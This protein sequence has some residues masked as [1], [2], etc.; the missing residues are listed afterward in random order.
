MITLICGLPNA[1][2]TTY[3]EQY[4][5]V[6]H[7]DSFTCRGGQFNNCNRLASELKGD[8]CV[9]GVYNSVR[10]RKEFLEACKSNSPKVCIWIDTPLD[11]C[12]KREQAYRKRPLQIVKSHHALFEPPTYD[13]GWDK[14]IIIKGEQTNGI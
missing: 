13:E 7:F 6:I 4:D 1:G 10:R 14:I 12:L 3:S 2:K 9:E 8:V 5:N 11:E